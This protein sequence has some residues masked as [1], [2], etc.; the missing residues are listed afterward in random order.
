MRLHFTQRRLGAGDLPQAGRAGGGRWT[1]FGVFLKTDDAFDNA[2]YGSHDKA[3]ADQK[4][5][6][7][8]HSRD[9]QRQNQNALAVGANGAAQLRL[10]QGN[11]DNFS[12]LQD[13]H[14]D[15]THNARLGAHQRHQRVRNQVDH[16]R[17]AQIISGCDRAFQRGS[18]DQLPRAV[19][20]QNDG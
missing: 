9:D 13:R 11:L 18:E 1:A 7:A 8:R 10:S 2:F 14:A 4:D 17:I 19:P 12:T 16:S 3:A 20:A 5:Q 6:K 15:H